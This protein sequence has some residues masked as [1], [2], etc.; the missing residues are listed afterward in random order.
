MESLKKRNIEKSNFGSTA[1]QINLLKPNILAVVECLDALKAVHMA[2]KKDKQEHGPDLTHKIEDAIKK[3]SHEA[4]DI[5]D[6]ILTRK[7]L[8][9]STRNALNV[10]QR[11]RFLF[12][13]PSNIDCILSRMGFQP[14]QSIDRLCI[15][16]TV[17]QHDYQDTDTQY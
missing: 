15:L 2:L 3:A 4:H 17:D 10:L 6:E 16:D 7:D 9:D 1:S 14:C 11:Y 5:F 13:L 12:N 8:A